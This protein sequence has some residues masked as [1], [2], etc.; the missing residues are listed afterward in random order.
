[1]VRENVKETSCNLDQVFITD[2]KTRIC[3]IITL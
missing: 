1:M 3:F 2:V